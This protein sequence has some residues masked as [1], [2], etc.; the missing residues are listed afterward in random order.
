[1]KEIK[2]LK[3]NRDFRRLYSSGAHRADRHIVVY[4]LK[5]RLGRTRIGLTASKTIG[6]AVT[7]NRARRLMRESYRL[8]SDKV[9]SGYDV[10]IVARKS[11]AKEKMPVIKSELERSLKKLRLIKNEKDNIKAD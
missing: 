1:M 2:S 9:I 6:N 7:R 5:N 3:L 11:C 4:V 10:V 8:L